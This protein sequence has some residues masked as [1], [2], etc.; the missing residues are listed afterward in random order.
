MK[1][2]L[3]NIA[4]F[5]LP[6]LI[7]AITIFAMPV[8]SKYAYNYIAKGGCQA[9]PPWIYKHLFEDTSNI[10]IA[11]IGTSHTM[12]AVND[13]FLQAAID[14][15]LHKG[16]ACKN[17]SFCGFGRNL[18]YL[19]AKD[20]LEHKH[21]RMIVL[22]VRENESHTGHMSF[23]YLATAADLTAA[24]KFINQSYLPDLYKAFLF[25]L[26]YLREFVTH[27]DA[28]RAMQ[29]P[30]DVY[31]YNVLTQIANPN[32]LEKALNKT[33]VKEERNIK[34]VEYAMETV[35]MYY[36]NAI[37]QLAKQH[38]AQLVLLYLP[39]YN[40]IVSDDEIRAKY[41]HYGTVII[42]DSTILIDKN[43]WADNEH[44]NTNAVQNLNPSLTNC[45]INLLN[46]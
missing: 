28:K 37:A 44:L 16:Y 32:D 36:V 14:T 7:I 2:W 35:P 26:Q 21:P 10:D 46:R 4:L 40:R 43:N 45:L 5:A 38:N 24:P 42:P 6:L 34:Q 23:P 30:D 1:N 8:D 17:I 19:I 9:R 20:L 25:K 41:A 29:V 15:V 13:S 22:E 11:F 33:K 31:G 12:G 3:R 18:D 39:A 27:E